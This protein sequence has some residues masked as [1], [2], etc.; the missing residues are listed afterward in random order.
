MSDK[1]KAHQVWIHKSGTA[2]Q[3]YG[4]SNEDSEKAGYIETVVY[5]GVDSGKLYSKP[6]S[7]WHGR[8]TISCESCDGFGDVGSPPDDYG[9][10]QDCIKP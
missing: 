8:M 5:R 9:R 10:C 3:A 6:L 1:P 7:A 2:Y 4:I